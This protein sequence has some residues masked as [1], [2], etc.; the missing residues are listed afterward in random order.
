M[1]LRFTRNSKLILFYKLLLWYPSKADEIQSQQV[2]LCLHCGYASD[3]G[4]E[5]RA[6][7]CPPPTTHHCDR[8][9]YVEVGCNQFFFGQAEAHTVAYEFE[10]RDISFEFQYPGEDAVHTPG[11]R[12]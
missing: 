8:A 10:R 3:I 12:Y 6:R 5:G 1:Y 9:M 4:A 2:F 7:G 11:S